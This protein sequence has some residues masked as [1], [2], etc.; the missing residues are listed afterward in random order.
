MAKR[1]IGKRGRKWPLKKVRLTNVVIKTK[2]PKAFL[3]DLGVLLR[4]YNG[5]ED[6]GFSVKETGVKAA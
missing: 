5:G 6:V 2:S 1:T 3:T 4:N